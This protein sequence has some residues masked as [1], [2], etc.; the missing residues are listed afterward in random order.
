MI[1][2]ID[3][4]LRATGL[5]V[6][7]DDGTTDV[8]T[9]RPPA[10]DGTILS[11]ADRIT[12]IADKVEAWADLAHGDTVV[13]E[14]VLHHAPSKHRS[15]ML[16]GWWMTAARVARAVNGSVYVVQPSNRAMY[17]TG[18]GKAAKNDVLAAVRATYPQFAATNDDEA[19]AVV[20]VAMGA[21]ALGRPIDNPP[22]THLAAMRKITKE[23]Q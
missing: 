12:Y 15:K 2:G 21:R 19:D 23:T 10:D 5:A 11:I 9:I 20:L 8:A 6:L 16:G 7:C 3:W 17:A 14:G 4:S 18:S 1:L 22:P 13:L